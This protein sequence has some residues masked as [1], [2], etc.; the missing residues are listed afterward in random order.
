[1]ICLWRFMSF[2]GMNRLEAKSHSG[3]MLKK[4]LLVLVCKK[5]PPAW[6]INGHNKRTDISFSHSLSVSQLER[7]HS[8]STC[9]T[10][11]FSTQPQ[12][13]GYDSFM[14]IKKTALVPIKQRHNVNKVS[15]T[16][17]IHAPIKRIKM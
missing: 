11:T 15:A 9:T 5:L 10:P 3:K 12:N 8:L 7:Y 2:V 13:K 4:G 6:S 1:M 17:Y 14:T 16:C